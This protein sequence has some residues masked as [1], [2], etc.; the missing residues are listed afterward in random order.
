VF[1]RN[2]ETKYKTLIYGDYSVPEFEFLK[3]NEWVFTEKVDGT[4]IRVMWQNDGIPLEFRGK[5]DR[6]QL[7]P[8]LLSRLPELFT[9]SELRELFEDNPACLYGEGYGS[10]IQKGGKYRE[11]QSFVLFDV[12]IGR[13]WLQRHDI[14]DIANKLGI[15][16]VP[17]IGTGSLKHMVEIT[18][19][20]FNSQWGDFTA[21]GIVARP[22]TELKARNGSRIITKIKHA[23]F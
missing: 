19:N 11:D 5:T 6:A 21:E 4:N 3:D 16:V 2:P 8:P 18:M 7:P 13:W 23:D 22:K 15:D 9:P 17:I 12:Q 1:K 20:G 10:K 14:E